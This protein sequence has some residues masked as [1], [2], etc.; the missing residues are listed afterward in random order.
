M[1][2]EVGLWDVLRSGSFAGTPRLKISPLPGEAISSSWHVSVNSGLTDSFVDLAKRSPPRSS[3]HTSLPCSGHVY[4]C[5]GVSLEWRHC[6]DTR[7]FHHALQHE[8]EMRG[9]KGRSGG[10][11]VLLGRDAPWLHL[12]RAAILHLLKCSTMLGKTLFK[13]PSFLGEIF[14]GGIFPQILKV[15]CNPKEVKN[16]LSWG[17]WIKC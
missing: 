6:K 16:P 7:G 10:C 3:A 12:H 11:L 17:L 4:L 14:P 15:I 1:V 8:T 2:R 9:K 5:R 13:C